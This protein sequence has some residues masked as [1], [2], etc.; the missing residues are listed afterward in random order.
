MI[1]RKR[2][3]P[4]STHGRLADPAS[5][6]FRIA[7]YPFYRMARVSNLYAACLDRGRKPRG[8][9]QPRWRVLMIL[10]EHNPA[11]SVAAVSPSGVRQALAA[12]RTES[13]S[14]LAMRERGVGALPLGR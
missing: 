6:E 11:A 7:N 8:M 1:S 4:V 9:D 12:N 13:E 3:N 5:V 10:S 2:A 14:W